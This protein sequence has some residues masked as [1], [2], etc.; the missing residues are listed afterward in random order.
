MNFSK[1]KD[2]EHTLVLKYL[3]PHIIDKIEKFWGFP[4]C[5]EYLNDLLMDS[6]D[7]A[8]Q[9]FSK[10]A[11][12]AILFFLNEHDKCFP[13]FDRQRDPWSDAR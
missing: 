9:G 3:H 6:R 2:H 8:R 7:G 12:K 10:E 13:Q 5:R 11:F 4:V 1:Y